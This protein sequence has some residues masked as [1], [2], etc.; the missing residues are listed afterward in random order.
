MAAW[1]LAGGSLLALG[2]ASRFEGAPTAFVYRVESLRVATGACDARGGAEEPPD[3]PFFV[4]IDRAAV[5]I[6]IACASLEAC[7]RIASDGRASSSSVPPWPYT[8]ASFAFTE[9]APPASGA[10][11]GKGVRVRSNG[12]GSIA[13]ALE[14]TEQRLEAVPRESATG[15]CAI[16]V[17]EGQAATLPCVIARRYDATLVVAR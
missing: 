16:D 11:R 12:P 13:F 6:A 3:T 2:C 10:C 1:L 14:I 5:A 7:D 17:A 15:A 4:V 9:D 8:L